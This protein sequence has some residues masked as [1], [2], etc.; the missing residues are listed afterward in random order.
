MI[1]MPVSVYPTSDNKLLVVG[2]GRHVLCDLPIKPFKF[3]SSNYESDTTEK[4]NLIGGGTTHIYKREFEVLPVSPSSINSRMDQPEID[5]TIELAKEY[6]EELIKLT[7]YLRDDG[8]PGPIEPYPLFI[9]IET[10]STAGHFPRADRDAILS[11]Q[12]KYVD[13]ETVVLLNKLDST[14]SEMDML[15][16]FIDY[17][18]L[19]PS[20]K[21]ADVMVGYNHNRFDVPYLKTRIDI[22]AKQE[23]AL[24]AA[25][26]TLYR[27][28]IKP[29]GEP[30]TI[31]DSS[32]LHI[33][34]TKGEMVS[35]IPGMVNIDL[36]VHAKTDL[37]LQGLPSRSLKNVAVAYGG[38]VF[39]IELE[40]KQNMKHL[41]KTDKEKFM[42]YAISDITATEHLWNV[43]KVR[44]EAASELL[45]CPISLLHRASSG[46]KS[47]LALYRAC[48]KNKYISLH[49]NG[50]EKR[51]EW[52]YS[53]AP[54]YQGA[55]VACYYSGYFSD[56]TY[57]DAKSLY[58]NI[59]H[60][61][62]VSYDR[63]TLEESIPYELWEEELE[64]IKDEDYTEQE[65]LENNPVNPLPNIVT[66]GEPD[67]KIIYLPDDNYEM[68]L[69][70]KVDLVNDGF[71]KEVLNHY[72]GVRDE[73]KN[74][75]KEYYTKYL[76]TK[77]E[78]YK[79]EFTKFDSVQ[80]EAKVVNNTF[81]GIQGNKYYDIADLPAAIFVTAIG[82]WT[83]TEMVNLFGKEAVIEI[84]TDGLLLD[85]TKFD[86]KLDDINETIKSKMEAT[87]GMKKD[88]MNFKLE[89]EDD[90]S[91]YMYK[92]KNYILK[93]NSDPDNLVI[94]G[95]AFK[96]YSKAPVI[97]RAATIMANAVM[98]HPNDFTAYDTAA[99]EALDVYT[100]RDNEGIDPFKFTKVLKKNLEE[101]KGFN[102]I[103][104]YVEN[105][106]KTMSSRKIF[107][108]KKKR[109]LYCAK[110]L[111][112][113]GERDKY[114]K[115][116]VPPR[117]KDYRERIKKCNTDVE[118]NSVIGLLV[119]IQLAG[120]DRTKSSTHIMDMMIKLNQRGQI[121]E[122]DDVLE[123]YYTR[124]SNQYILIED[125]TDDT[126]IDYQ[127][128]IKDINSI[129]E[130]FKFA[131]PKLNS[132]NIADLL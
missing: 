87:F 95:S 86:L 79:Y 109:T 97:Q 75:A 27:N 69:K 71:M 82:R 73:Y 129:I 91:V 26:S 35:F 119:Q 50:S 59:M 99:K 61:F 88:R 104:V 110:T 76:E 45:S 10:D 2:N 9:D 83:M 101:Y 123:Y 102:N 40:N 96:G 93:K 11:I 1:N 52:L 115:L 28:S 63:Y 49:P 62:N 29:N 22:W 122:V 114:G 128:Y 132:L 112:Q 85:K 53:K 89:L 92:Q 113:T 120:K 68:I 121:L 103:E 13:S 108:E 130:R 36:F 81:Y 20:G 55:L 64:K 18:K 8:L 24:K 72:N 60:D 39:D 77:D 15:Y 57:L 124:T 58:P 65:R 116:K 34:K 37:S 33:Q 117:E 7:K 14:R 125:A 98:Y 131:N 48:R 90:G 38:V 80:A 31:Y 106:D 25:M 17:V 12:V 84:D 32:W 107:M 47:Y 118:L 41:L 43:Y 78:K 66:Y 70:F 74:K 5:Y 19:S 51:Y 30:T 16:E 127:R 111:F 100:I 21:T 54:K 67:A 105:I 46:Q 56:T 94:K 6:P 23:P 44:L 4:V 3:E 126:D 42:K